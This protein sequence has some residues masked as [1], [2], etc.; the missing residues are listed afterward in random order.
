MRNVFYKI[1]AVA[2][3][4]LVCAVVF[5]LSSQ[6]VA[7]CGVTAGSPGYLIVPLNES[8]I[9]LS[10]VIVNVKSVVVSHQGSQIPVPLVTSQFTLSNPSKRQVNLNVG[11]PMTHN[12]GM[13]FE[14]EDYA[15]E[16]TFTV[17]GTKI[18]P[19]KKEAGGVDETR[20]GSKYH[21]YYAW[22]MT[23]KPGE[24][25]LVTCTYYAEWAYDL[26]GGFFSFIVQ[27]GSLWSEKIDQAEF[28]FEMSEATYRYYKDDD[29]SFEIAPRGYTVKERLIEW[30]FR[31]WLPTQ[32]ISI[33]Y[34]QIMTQEEFERALKEGG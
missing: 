11:F 14:T 33:S 29:H 13:F 21:Y 17:D 26:F 18:T 5:V 15:N 16:R 25:K 34:E 23:F 6:K 1:I 31:N 24:E 4:S 22:P 19:V 32:D 20:I 30:Q 12:T 3:V 9:M 8:D 28:S 27:P 10:K 7:A 2:T